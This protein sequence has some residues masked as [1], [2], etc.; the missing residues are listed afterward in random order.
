MTLRDS[1]GDSH[2]Q[3]PLCGVD[4]SR[5][6]IQCAVNAPYVITRSEA[7]GKVALAELLEAIPRGPGQYGAHCR[8]TWKRDGESFTTQSAGPRRS[9]SHALPYHLLGD[10][11]AYLAR[12]SRQRTAATRQPWAASFVV[13]FRCGGMFRVPPFATRRA[14]RA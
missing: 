1:Y 8:L 5:L 10:P 9:R 7:R 4:I 12:R 11:R 3:L 14:P 2:L 6:C 13:R